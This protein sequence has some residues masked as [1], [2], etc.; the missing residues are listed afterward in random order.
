MKILII[1]VKFVITM[2][3]QDTKHF[4][5]SPGLAQQFFLTFTVVFENERT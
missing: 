2:P 3:K 4:F 5:F 1:K